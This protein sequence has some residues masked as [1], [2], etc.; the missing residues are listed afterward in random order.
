[1]SCVFPR[2]KTFTFHIPIKI[3][4][5]CQHNG[6]KKSTW[7]T[8]WKQNDKVN[9]ISS[10]NVLWVVGKEK[11]K[12]KAKREKTSIWSHRN[13][14]IPFLF[15]EFRWKCFEVILR[16]FIAFKEVARSYH[17]FHLLLISDCT[18][19]VVRLKY[20]ICWRFITSKRSP[21]G[22][23]ARPSTIKLRLP[24]VMG[25][26]FQVKMTRWTYTGI[27]YEFDLYR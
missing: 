25:D 20:A 17:K 24:L 3:F 6:I 11:A 9:S 18:A 21:N 13:A 4:Y 16:Q 14:L 2:N 10:R 19:V 22:A 26:I 5:Q 8:N 7:A 23:D 12:V 1:M 15:M 27:E